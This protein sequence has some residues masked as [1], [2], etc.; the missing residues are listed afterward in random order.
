MVLGAGFSKSVAGFPLTKEMLTKFRTVIKEQEELGHK[1]RMGWG[2][3]II[4][5]IN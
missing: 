1:N 2:N 5:F 3:R 4:E